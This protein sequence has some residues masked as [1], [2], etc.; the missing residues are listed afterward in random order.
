MPAIFLVITRSATSTLGVIAQLA[1]C[2]VVNAAVLAIM[3][4]GVVVGIHLGGAL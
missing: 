3:A 2:A 4:A 1:L